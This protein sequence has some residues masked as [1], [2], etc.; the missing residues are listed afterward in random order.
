MLISNIVKKVNS[1]LAGEQL[2]REQMLVSLDMAIDKINSKLS[3]KFPV[4]SDLE[5]GTLVYEAFPEKYIRT[6]MCPGAAYFFYLM[7]EEGSPAAQA[8]GE[9]FQE[10][11]FFM[12]RDYMSSIPLEYQEADTQGSVLMNLTGAEDNMFALTDIQI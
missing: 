7:D 1:L 9:M 10:G 12:L 6:V 2:S 4:L 11:L 5:A 8:Y 3:S